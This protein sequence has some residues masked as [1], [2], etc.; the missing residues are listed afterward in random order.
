MLRLA[1]NAFGDG[2]D[3]IWT[4]LDLLGNAWTK[5]MSILGT[6]QFGAGGTPAKPNVARTEHRV[7]AGAR[8]R[9]NEAIFF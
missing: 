8:S 1:W 6:Q 9:L 5:T 7:Q 3:K 2:L 4:L